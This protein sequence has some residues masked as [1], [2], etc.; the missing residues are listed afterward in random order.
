MQE[1]NFSVN[2]QASLKVEQVGRAQ[3]PVIVI[4]DFGVDLADVIA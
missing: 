2:P 3:T 4:D 1:V